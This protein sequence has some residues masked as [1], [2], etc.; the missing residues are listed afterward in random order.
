[1]NMMRGRSLLSVAGQW[2]RQV[3]D[4]SRR[5]L[6]SKPQETKAEPPAT[7]PANTHLGFKLPGYRPS[8]MDKKILIW[9]GRFKSADQIPEF[10]SFE[11]IDAS[12]NRMRVKVC[13]GMMVT[14]IAACLIMVILGKRAAGRH[15]SLTGQNMEKKAKLRQEFQLQQQEAAS[16]AAMSGKAQ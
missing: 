8:D 12:R 5:T 10:V 13:Y 14:T 1:M 2:R 4:A 6:C 9:S 3:V 16:A 15:E 11:M 7:A